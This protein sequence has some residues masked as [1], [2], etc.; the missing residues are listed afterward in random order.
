MNSTENLCVAELIG[1][2]LGIRFAAGTPGD[3]QGA[4]AQIIRT[5][6]YA[7]NNYLP[8]SCS[9]RVALLN[10][11]DSPHNF[12]VDSRAGWELIAGAETTMDSIPGDHET[13]VR[14]PHARVLAEKLRALIA[15]ADELS[16]GD[17]KSGP[18]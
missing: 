14:E 1:T 5:N 15:A 6:R 2:R 17:D 8:D 11:N 10:A 18:S 12:P 16:R 7:I 13:M 4:L 9:G 3:P